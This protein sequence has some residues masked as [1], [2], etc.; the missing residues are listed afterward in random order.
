MSTQG[1]SDRRYDLVVVGGGIYG[2]CLALT[3]ALRGRRVALIERHEFGQATSANSLGI[4]HGGLRYLQSFDLKR[5]HESVNER[6]WFLRH[7][8]GLVKPLGFVMPLYGKG[9][10]RH[11]VMRPALALNDFLSRRRN[12]CIQSP[13]Q[14]PSSEI[15]GR[16][17]TIERF[18]AVRR[19]GL[20]GAACWYD[21][22]M[23]DPDRLFNEIV[24]RARHN[25]AHCQDRVEGVQLTTENNHVT[26]IQ[27]L[28]RRN[29]STLSYQAPVIVNCA[30]PWCREA[31][32]SFDRDI[33]RLFQPS[34]AFNVVLDR[35]PLAQYGLAVSPK[36][37]PHRSCFLLPRGD[38]T[39][40]GTFHAPWTD[41][42]RSPRPT[43]QQLEL[44]LDELN[45]AIPSLRVT[46][47]DI[48]RVHA[49]LLPASGTASSSTAN[50]PVIH[51]HGMVGGPTGLYS[52][53]GVKYTTARCVA[54]QTLQ[55]IERRQPSW[56]A[57]RCSAPQIQRIVIPPKRTIKLSS[58]PALRTTNR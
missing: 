21:G 17:A 39:L 47:A 53:S 2:V 5:F 28:D 18:P 58:E 15:L 31:A 22:V 54:Q 30:G 49:G 25:G 36:N 11:M 3:S 55:M 32:K 13:F 43:D 14:I 8:P 48:L 37:D 44:F 24:F 34:L 42:I 52:V 57:G 10:R 27:A 41:T 46:R 23:T 6:S 38:H 19:E 35:K 26:G 51:D 1:P 29:G 12:D 4:L 50:R 40:A 20:Q 7:F 45:L 9:L 16:Q 33:P 56:P